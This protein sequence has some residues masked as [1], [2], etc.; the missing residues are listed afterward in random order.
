[1]ALAIANEIIHQEDSDKHDGDLEQVEA[2]VHF[3]V[4]H[5]PADDDKERNEE[6]SDL[7]AG[8][9]GHANGEIHLVL[10]GDGYSGGVLGGISDNGQENETD[11]LLGQ[12]AGLGD[13]IDGV[14]HVFGAESDNSGGNGEGREGDKEVQLGLF[15]LVFVLVEALRV[16]EHLG[17]S[18]IF[19]LVGHGVAHQPARHGKTLFEAG[20][21]VLGQGS[22]RP[23]LGS[24]LL[25]LFVKDLL[26]R[27]ELEE[28]IRGVDEEQDNRGSAGELGDFVLAGGAVVVEDGRD[29][30]GS[31]GKSE[32]RGSG[33]RDGG[34]EELLFAAKTTEEEAEA[35]DEQQV[36]EDGSDERGLDDFDFV[37]GERN[38]GNDEF[39]GVAKGG[40]EQAAEGLT[41]AQGDFFRGEAQHGS[42]GDDGDEVDDKDSNFVYA[43]VV[44][45]DADRGG[46]DEEVDPRVEKGAL[47]LIRGR[48]GSFGLDMSNKALLFRLG[49]AI[50]VV[51]L[52]L[53]TA[54]GFRLG[55]VVVGLAISQAAVG[56]VTGGLAGQ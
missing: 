42:E 23:R 15:L 44:E 54:V 21:V 41:S 7:H 10:D 45:G 11:K 18:L 6:Q 2:E 17:E 47:E 4:A 34:V 12:A 52:L 25:A 14:D 51:V 9:N 28:Q 53:D 43:G 56:G 27:L 36:G 20:T 3:L 37:V 48:K 49:L 19:V 13:C 35:H 33:L 31:D 29:N 16:H 26:M 1:M 50:V 40:V 55:R 24:H 22:S 38:D 39:D 8:A 30:D 46:E 5:A 32:K